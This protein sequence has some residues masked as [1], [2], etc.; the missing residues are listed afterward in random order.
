[1][2]TMDHFQPVTLEFEGEQYEIPEDKIWGLLR[3]LEQ[4]M[5]FNFLVQKLA[6]DDVPAMRVYEAYAQALRYAGC[7]NIDPMKVAKGA[8]QTDLVRMAYELVAILR[9]MNPP[10]DMDILSDAE[11]NTAE[12]Q[13]EDADEDDKKKGQ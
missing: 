7:K 8:N 9:M 12:E 4:I 10:D 5:G 1:M 6:V 11:A 13:G 2:Y 3:Q